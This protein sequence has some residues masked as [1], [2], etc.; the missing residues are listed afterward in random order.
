MKLK[1]IQSINIIHVHFMIH[2]SIIILLR[3]FFFNQKLLMKLQ[4]LIFN[5][6]KFNSLNEKNMKKYNFENF[7]CFSHIPAPNSHTRSVSAY[8][9]RVFSHS[10]QG[11]LAS[12]SAF[13]LLI[14]FSPF[15]AGF[16]LDVLYYRE[17]VGS[18]GRLLETVSLSAIDW[19]AFISVVIWCNDGADRIGSLAGALS[20]INFDIFL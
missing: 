16:G 9:K 5:S 11:W 15:I 2:L 4:I 18:F 19:S 20:F 1:I 7:H 17:E 14:V 8:L 3:K 6:L 10:V 12:I 13:L